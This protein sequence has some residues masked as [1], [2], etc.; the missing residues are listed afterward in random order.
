MALEKQRLEINFSQGLDLKSDEKQVPF[1]RFLRL[2]NTVFEKIGLLQKRNGFKKLTSL[3]DSSSTYTTTFKGNLTAIGTSINAYSAPTDSWVNRGQL[4]P[5]DVT[6]LSLF[7]NYIIQNYSDAAVSSNGLV[8]SVIVDRNDN[9][10]WYQVTDT[11]T[12]QAVVAP[13]SI[14][15]DPSNGYPKVFVLGNF[16]I[17]VYSESGPSKLKYIPINY[18]G[19]AVGSSVQISASYT[20]TASGGF[21]GV[22]ANNVLYIA[23]NGD[24]MG[25]AI[26]LIK[27]NEH[28]TLSST[29][30]IASTTGTIISVA[31][32]TTL[33]TPI[34]YVSAWASSHLY[35]GVFDQNLATITAFTSITTDNITALTSVAKNGTA[36]IYEEVVNAYSY[37]AAIPSHYVKKIRINQDGSIISSSTIIRSVGLASKAFVYNGT[38]YVLCSYSSSYQPT[39]FLIDSTGRI[40]AKLA[41]SN[42]GGYLTAGLPSATLYGDTVSIGYL[43]RDMI[44]PVN[45]SQG[46]SNAG[47]G[48]YAQVGVNLATFTFSIS[49]I[50]TSELAEKLYITGGFMWGYD[51]VTAAEHGF[52]VWADN[53]EAVGAL[54]A[55][56]IA[57]QDYYYQVTYEWVDNQGNL[58]RSAPSI[59]VVYSIS[60]PPASF[61]GNRTSGSPILTSVSSTTN[62]QVGQAV[63]GTGIPASTFIQ[64]I[65]SSS[66]ITLNKNATSG[67]S[68]STTVTPTAVSAI[69]LN[70]PTLRLTYKTGVNI[71]IYRWSTAQQTYY[72]ITSVTGPLAND[73]TTDSVSYTDTQADSSIVGN[74]II[75]TTGGVVENIAPPA[76][77]AMA[78]Y[79]SRLIILDSEDRNLL[80]FSKQVIENTPVDMSDLF[81]IYVPPTQSVEGSSGPITALSA[82][83]DKLIIFKANAIYYMVGTGPDN[84]GANN[85]FS[86]PIFITSTVGCNL[87]NSIVFT[88]SGIMFQSAKGIWLLGRDLS[89]TYIGSAVEDFNEFDVLS[90]INIPTKNQTRFTLSDGTILVYNYFFGQW[91]TFVGIPAVA[92]TAFQGLH[93]FIN[94]FGDLYQENPGSY[95]DGSTPVLMGLTTGWFNPQGLEG[96][97]RAYWMNFIGEYKSPHFLVVNIDF[98]YKDSPDQSTIVRP[99]NYNNPY[100]GD[101]LYGSTYVYG[102]TE[103]LEQWRIFFQKQHC[104]AFRINIDE[105][106]NASLGTAAGEG[107]TL[108]GLTLIYGGKGVYPRLPASRSTG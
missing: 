22:V 106:F 77:N 46:A 88:P 90:A 36:S 25:G 28:L 63:S 40:I 21:D 103:S 59:P 61:T 7:R 74:N 52:H 108:S 70:I 30:I 19:L 87:Q 31:A 10:A 47:Q 100:G 38:T 105:V 39:Y 33:S 37:D 86:D 72:Q 97:E 11:S 85:D 29:V 99:D 98:D 75:Y 20:A 71:V 83:D 44:I 54:S 93:T 69:K 6:T 42:G 94:S 5:V 79:K 55:G 9:S 65:D 27:L 57:T 48:V 91:S 82:M 51:G 49:E 43:I 4:Q 34:I 56:S 13:T 68:T 58:H 8:C 2:K 67:S 107:L 35:T 92:S 12:G 15:V 26:R 1:G 41:Y 14:N 95:L 50:V 84:T 53:V 23:L 62:L 81:T 3:P 76:T 16:F 24:D 45:K 102:G 66:Q 78:L 104:E 101:P 32:D 60:T 17:I 80:W 89:T 64:S 96:F 18:L 73:K